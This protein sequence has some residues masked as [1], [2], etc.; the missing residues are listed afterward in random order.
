MRDGGLPVKRRLDPWTTERPGPLELLARLAGTT[1][2]RIPQGGGSGSI[3]TEDIAKALGYVHSTHSQMIAFALA[4]GHT[5]E[6]P[7]IQEMVF[8]VLI[9]QLLADRRTRHLV[10]GANR[11]RAR[12]LL[13]DAFHDLTSFREANWRQAA[14]RCHMRQQT[15]KELYLAVAG[16]LRTEAVGAAHTAMTILFSRK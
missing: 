15:Y 8:P 3:T 2:F 4:T 11:F 5:N 10:A 6:W 12:L 13:Y 9:S 14:K 16:F 7:K 1:S